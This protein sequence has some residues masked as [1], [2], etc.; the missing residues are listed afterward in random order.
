MGAFGKEDAT[1]GPQLLLFFL[2]ME[3]LAEPGAHRLVIQ[4]VLLGNQ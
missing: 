1:E 2:E 3:F 4:A